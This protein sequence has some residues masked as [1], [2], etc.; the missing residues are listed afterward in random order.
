M[1]GKLPRGF[2]AECERSSDEVR[3]ELRITLS[4]RL[5]PFVFAEFLGVPVQALSDAEAVGLSSSEIGVLAQELS[6]F[7]ALTVGDGP[8]RAILYNDFHHPNRIASD[9]AH[10]LSHIYLR[11]PLHPAIGVGGGRNWLDDVEEE[12]VWHSGALLVPRDGAY[13]LLKRGYTLRQA[14]IH[15]G[16]S[17][18]LFSWRARITGVT[19]ILGLPKAS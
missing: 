3:K 5:D 19:K 14:A 8:R 7:S 18:Q 13:I 9:M 12:A 6:G 1:A 16:V 11:H 10:E 2:K 4:D 17:D 15:M